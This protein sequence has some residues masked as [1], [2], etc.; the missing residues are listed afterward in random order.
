VNPLPPAAAP[1]RPLQ[2]SVWGLMVVML[3]FSVAAALAY[4][5]R[6]GAEGEDATRLVGMIVVLAGPLLLMTL[7]SLVLA[8][9]QWLR[10]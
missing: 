6:R 9:V 1:K 2:L 7:I 5:M 10:R 4:Y 3:G 8:L